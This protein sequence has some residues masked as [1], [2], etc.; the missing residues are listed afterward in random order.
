MNMGTDTEKLAKQVLYLQQKQNGASNLS[1][2]CLNI[3]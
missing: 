3:V 1:A 2:A